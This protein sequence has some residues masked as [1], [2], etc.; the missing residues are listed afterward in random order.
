M[1]QGKRNYEALFWSIA[2]PGF[3]QFINKKYYKGTI[4]LILE[5]VINVM[6]NFN[7]IIVYSFN[8]NIDQAIG[9]T[10]YQWLMFYP[11]FYL[12][13]LWDAYRDA[14]EK[15]K[16]YLYLPFAFGAFFVTVGLIYSPRLLIFGV[17]LGPVFL[18]MLFLIPGFFFGL[19]LRGLLL[20][21]NY[22]ELRV[23]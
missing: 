4:L 21:R 11:C 10:N 1:K 23:G 3:G 16:P 9:A 15:T 17:L 8:G 2:L 22:R 5:V 7:L 20:K 13:S 18:P 19:V 6:S 14:N 12:F